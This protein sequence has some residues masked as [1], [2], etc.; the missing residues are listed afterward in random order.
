MQKINSAEPGVKTRRKLLAG[1]G[2]FFV[3]PLW[4]ATGLFFRKKQVIACAPP[5][6][7]KTMK[8]LSQDGKLIEVDISKIKIL[9]GKISDQELQD[10]IKK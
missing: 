3:F 5:E 10:W 6:E 8:V 7:K 2:V 1:I 9:K 4:K